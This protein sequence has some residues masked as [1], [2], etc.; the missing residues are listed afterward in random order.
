M[1]GKRSCAAWLSAGRASTRSGCWKGRCSV[2]EERLGRCKVAVVVDVDSRLLLLELRWDLG[3]RKRRRWT[4]RRDR[5]RPAV[6]EEGIGVGVEGC[7]KGLGVGVG[8]SFV[9]SLFEGLGSLKE[10]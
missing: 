5:C 8:R 1:V 10:D 4:T 3:R 7:S 2:A 9:G 6:A